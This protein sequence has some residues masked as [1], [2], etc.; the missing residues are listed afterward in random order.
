MVFLNKRKKMSYHTIV[1]TRLINVEKTTNSDNRFPFASFRWYR[2]LFKRSNGDGNSTSMDPEK[3]G[4]LLRQQLK[5]TQIRKLRLHH[6]SN[7][8]TVL[9]NDGT[10]VLLNLTT[11]PVLT[12]LFTCDY[13][14]TRTHF[15]SISPIKIVLGRF[16][17]YFGNSVKVS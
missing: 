1:V 3:M 11:I 2:N 16:S 6:T 8:A 17:F 9:S 10:A 13:G 4:L 12:S 15:N 14:V 5:L 7:S